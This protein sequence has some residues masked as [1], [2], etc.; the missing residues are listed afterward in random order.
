M[1]MDRRPNLELSLGSKRLGLLKEA[2]PGWA[3]RRHVQSR[4]AP[5]YELFMPVIEAAAQSLGVQAIATPVPIK[6]LIERLGVF[7]E[8]IRA[9]RRSEK[10][11]HV[12]R[13][14]LDRFR[15]WQML[16]D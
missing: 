4:D 1:G 3:G 12:T 16:K 13:P 11:R 8:T 14:V 6:L 10:W 2:A 5:Q 9:I 15:K 7:G